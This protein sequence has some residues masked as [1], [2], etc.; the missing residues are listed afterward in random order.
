MN[1]WM[2]IRRS[3]RFRARAHLGVVLGAAAGS[4]ALIGALL[5]GDSVRGSLQDMALARLGSTDA[6]ISGGDRFFR[7]QLVG[8]MLPGNWMPSSN[9]PRAAA[10]LQLPGTASAQN[11]S[12]RA[13]QVQFLGV[14][15]EFWRMAAQSP[16]GKMA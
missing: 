1:S 11:A 6:A 12:A 2:L 3:L 9:L 13:N 5:V 16:M 10:M 14:G 15:G 7:E 8:E 4:A